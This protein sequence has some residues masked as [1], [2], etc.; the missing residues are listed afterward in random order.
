MNIK[1]IAFITLLAV[2]VA[3]CKD[4]ENLQR[5][6][7]ANARLE[8]SMRSISKEKNEIS[9]ELQQRINEI[10]ASQ[11]MLRELTAQKSQIEE[12]L[13]VVLSDKDRLQ[14]EVESYKAQAEEYK[15]KAEARQKLLEK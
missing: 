14:K 15:R 12:R 1:K 10:K 9:V 5:L 6:L 7:D 4:V 11:E 13:A 8:Q 3:S 2:M